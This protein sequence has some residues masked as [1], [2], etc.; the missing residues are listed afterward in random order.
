MKRRYYPEWDSYSK[1][2]EWLDKICK[3]PKCNYCCRPVKPPKNGYELHDETQKAYLEQYAALIIQPPLRTIM[4]R[5]I[6]TDE[7][8]E[9]EETTWVT[10]IIDVVMK[11]KEKLK[12]N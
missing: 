7:D 12:K 9:E 8:E 3:D 11:L 6:A 4:I 5:D 1:K 10:R 2:G